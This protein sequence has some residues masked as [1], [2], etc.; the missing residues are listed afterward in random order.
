MKTSIELLILKQIWGEI[1]PEEQIELDNYKNQSAD[2]KWLVDNLTDRKLLKEA[3]QRHGTLDV[4]AALQK[5]K[6]EL[7]LKS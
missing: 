5:A 2:N 7:G 4:E 1:T 6:Q 3:T